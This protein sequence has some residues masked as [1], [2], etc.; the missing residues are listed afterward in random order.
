MNSEEPY[1]VLQGRNLRR[2]MH[3]QDVVYVQRRLKEIG[4]YGDL[5]DGRYGIM[6][7]LTIS[8]FP[9]SQWSQAHRHSRPLHLRDA[10][11]VDST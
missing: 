1:P 3:G 2:G 4:F 11:V 8:Y 9:V 5:A 10:A 6:T 7:E